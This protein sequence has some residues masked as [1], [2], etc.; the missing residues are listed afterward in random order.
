MGGR[1]T[2]IT[3]S[4]AN[5]SLALVTQIRPTEAFKC[6]HSTVFAK[7]LTEA[8]VSS[9]ARVA[10]ACAT[11]TTAAVYSSNQRRGSEPLNGSFSLSPDKNQLLGRRPKNSSSRRR[12]NVGWLPPPPSKNAQFVFFFLPTDYSVL[13]TSLPI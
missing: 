3:H 5:A 7:Q 12:R 6:A 1:L 8:P 2:S 9:F 10:A 13:F 4:V 11:A